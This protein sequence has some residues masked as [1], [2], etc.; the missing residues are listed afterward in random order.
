MVSLWA[1]D[2]NSDELEI[3]HK[4][5]KDLAAR[6]SEDYWNMEMIS[7]LEQL[8]KC[9]SNKPLMD[10]LMYDVTAK[11]S[12][13]SL[14]QIRKDYNE[15]L[16]MVIA[17]L[18]VSPME[19][20]KPGIMASS[21]LLRPWT[22]EQ[23][24]NVIEEFFQSYLEKC[25][26]TDKKSI[27]IVES[28]EGK[29]HIPYEQIYFFEAREKKIYVCTGKDEYG[30]YHTIDKLAEELPE[31]FL[32]CHRGFIVNQYKIRKVALSQN[33]IYLADDYEIPL[34]RSYKPLL[35]GLGK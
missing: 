33:I 24:R 23:A 17:D 1:Y 30:F 28:K 21:L 22:K 7:A 14:L 3:L 4:V 29:I 13:E 19:Y 8:Q 10:M 16:L 26:Q 35:K 2:K 27:F 32:R 34:S 31:Q 6:L 9:L 18:K 25:T 5:A 15:M 20:M 12:I 11:N